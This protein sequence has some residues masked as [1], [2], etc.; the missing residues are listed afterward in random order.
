MI[1]LNGKNIATEQELERELA[2]I[3]AESAEELRKLFQEQKDAFV[4]E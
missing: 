2:G 4:S 3:D 1:V